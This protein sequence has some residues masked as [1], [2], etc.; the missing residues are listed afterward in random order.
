MVGFAAEETGA[1][2]PMPMRVIAS[3]M[4]PVSVVGK[5]ALLVGEVGLALSI[6]TG[7]TLGIFVDDT[8]H[9]LIKYLRARR[10][11]G[12]NAEDAIRSA[13]SSVGV[14]L[15]MTSIVLIAGFLV[16]ALSSFKMNAGM[17]LLTAITIGLALFA[18]FLFLPPLMLKLARKK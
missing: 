10:E 13:F 9:F 6:V 12:L 15:I 14:A 11:Q 16:L 17:G 4:V 3:C 2:K 1:S 5:L 8:V 18:D 7:M